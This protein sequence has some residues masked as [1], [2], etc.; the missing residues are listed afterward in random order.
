MKITL[1]TILAVLILASPVYLPAGMAYAQTT[2][3]IDSVIAPILQSQNVTDIKNLDCSKIK[4]EEFQKVGDAIMETMAPGERHEIME[5]MMGGENSQF[6][7][8][9]EQMMGQRY[10]GCISVSGYGS[11]M[12]NMMG[13]SGYGTMGSNYQNWKGG[14]NMMGNWFGNFGGGWFWLGPVLMILF[15]GLIIWA[16]IAFIK[17]VSGKSGGTQGDDSALKILKERY[18]RG[19]VDQKEF[20]EKSRQLKNL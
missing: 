12:M 20:E 6:L 14:G 10:L 2:S 1:S 9:M 3:T 19:E 4:N 8:G 16:I 17:S 11:G 18:A 13:G 15:W 7:K 5:Q